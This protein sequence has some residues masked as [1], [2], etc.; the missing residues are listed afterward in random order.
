MT[1]Q[2]FLFHILNLKFKPETNET[3]LEWCL[4]RQLVDVTEETVVLHLQQDLSPAT[5]MVTCSDLMSL[6]HRFCSLNKK[7]RN[8]FSCLAIKATSCG[9]SATWS[10]M[11]GRS[12]HW[13]SSSSPMCE[14][15]LLSGKACW[16]IIKRHNSV[17][18]LIQKDQL[19]TPPHP[20]HDRCIPACWELCTFLTFIFNWGLKTRFSQRCWARVKG[21]GWTM[22]ID[23]LCFVVILLLWV[24]GNPQPTGSALQEPR[25]HLHASGIIRLGLFTLII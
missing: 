13:W 12:Q 16:F 22:N 2:R 3:K 9:C 15:R 25:F 4:R 18:L 21:L 17:K 5:N 8:S 19:N 14:D 1:L 24:T 10:C 11:M 20:P 23:L 6:L 7:W